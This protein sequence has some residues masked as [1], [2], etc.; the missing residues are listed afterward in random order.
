LSG[1]SPA[2]EAKPKPVRRGPTVF[3]V[4]FNL[5]R[6]G[7][8]VLAL[9]P[10]LRWFWLGFTDGLTANPI[11]FLQRSAGTW[12]LVCLLV[13]L[14]ITP[15]R[16]ITGQGA[17]IKLRRMVGLFAFFY[18]VLHVTSYVWWD[19]W[20]DVAAIADDILKRPFILVGFASFVLLVPL[21]VTSTKGWIRR[22]GGQRW[23]LLHRLIYV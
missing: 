12:A 6:A 7:L 17:L 11:E 22:L 8:F 3:G 23:Q 20:F 18:A 14:A 10:F 5:F 1:P 13:T 9:V 19:Q 16:V 15:L 4:P 2:V 21:A